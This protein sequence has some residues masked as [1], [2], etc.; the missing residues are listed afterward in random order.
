MKLEKVN[1]GKN[2]ENIWQMIPLF[3]KESGEWK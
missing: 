1:R 3:K 2:V